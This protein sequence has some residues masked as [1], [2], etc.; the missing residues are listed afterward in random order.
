MTNVSISEPPKNTVQ[1]I[2][3]IV[4]KNAVACN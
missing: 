2:M 3:C 1:Q 4:Q